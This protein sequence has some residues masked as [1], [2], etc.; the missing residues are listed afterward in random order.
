MTLLT[1]PH[2][3]PV[4][5]RTR[6]RPVFLP[7]QGCAG[8]CVFCDQKSQSG[9]S[10]GPL[11]ATFARLEQELATASGP[12]C[13]V[14]FYG[15][16]FT[17]LPGEWPERFVA[18]AGRFRNQGHVKNIRCSTRPDTLTPERLTR[19]RTLGLNMIE[20]GVQSFDT[21]TLAESRRGYD[22]K[23]A[24]AGCRMVRDAGLV[25]GVHLLPGLPGQTPETFARDVDTVVN[26]DADAVRL[27]P[28]LVLEGTELARW[29]RTGRYSPWDEATT[30]NVLGR[31]LARCWQMG[32][33]VI[34][35]GLAAEP[36]LTEAVL[37]GPWH[38]SLGQRAAS[39]ALLSHIRERINELGARPSTLRV[40]RRF[41]SD[42]RGWKGERE[43]D[44]AT[45]GLPADAITT[46]SNDHFELRAD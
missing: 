36:S 1:F 18:L 8:R 14:G 27:H 16:T 29:W 30:L 4:V 25:L 21:Q 9:V 46:W 22:S 5:S 11:E 39:L 33:H 35:V 26:L 19:L 23:Q 34:R 45:L 13:D 38:P 3:R 32:V 15:G 17:A 31:A 24:L 28:C 10:P 41:L 6:V 37:A 2:P 12:A 40:P 44:Y 43:A 20:L 7:Q 42:V